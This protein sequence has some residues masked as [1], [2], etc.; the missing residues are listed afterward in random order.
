MKKSKP[1]KPV[2]KIHKQE[3]FDGECAMC[4]VEQISEEPEPIDW[5]TS[6]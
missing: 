4:E 1:R 6:R 2:C 5:E 3:L